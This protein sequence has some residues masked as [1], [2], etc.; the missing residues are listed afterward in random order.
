MPLGVAG[1]RSRSWIE[2]SSVADTEAEATRLA[3]GLRG[4]SSDHRTRIGGEHAN[5]LGNKATNRE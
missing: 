4:F 2:A 1:S 3:R 5:K